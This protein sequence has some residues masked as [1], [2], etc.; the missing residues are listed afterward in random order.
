M[1]AIL[2]TTVFMLST[3]ALAVDVVV[4]PSNNAALDK[5]KIEQIFLGKLK[6][7]DGSAKV[8]PISQVDSNP[9][10]EEFNTK[11]VG[12]S[13]SQLKA[14][15]SK[16]LFTGKGQPPKSMA[17]DQEVMKL[18]ADNPNVIGYVTSGSAD[19]S[20]KVLMSF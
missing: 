2:L 13:A 11:V 9:V 10:T 20:V 1:K 5:G 16:L 4:H 3:S 19:G 8:I 12:R 15:W 18:V 6:T 7:F 17:N 14:Y